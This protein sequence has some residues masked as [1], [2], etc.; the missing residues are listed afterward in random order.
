MMSRFRY[1]LRLASIGLAPALCAGSI[2]VRRT[3]IRFDSVQ[4]VG[5]NNRSSA[6]IHGPDRRISAEFVEQVSR[7]S[8]AG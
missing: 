7:G 6:L 3:P 5:V 1:T 8:L 4:S 2:A